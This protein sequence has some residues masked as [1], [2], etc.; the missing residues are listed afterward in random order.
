MTEKNGGKPP[1]SNTMQLWLLCHAGFQNSNEEETIGSSLG[2]MGKEDSDNREMQSV[3]RDGAEIVVQ[4]SQIFGIPR[5]M[6]KVNEEGIISHD[7]PSQIIGAIPFSTGSRSKIIEVGLKRTRS[8]EPGEGQSSHLG[9]IANRTRTRNLKY[10]AKLKGK[11]TGETQRGNEEEPID[12][13]WWHDEYKVMRHLNNWQMSKHT[14]Q[15]ALEFA[16]QRN[17]GSFCT[18]SIDKPENPTCFGLLLSSS[19]H[20]IHSKSIVLFTDGDAR[21]STTSGTMMLMNEE[22]VVFDHYKDR[23]QKSDITIIDKRIE[24]GTQLKKATTMTLQSLLT[25][26]DE[27]KHG[28]TYVCTADVVAIDDGYPWCYL[29]C[30]FCTRRVEHHETSYWCKKCGVVDGTLSRYRVKLDVADGESSAF[31]L[32]FESAG[33][34]VFGQPGYKMREKYDPASVPQAMKSMI[35]GKT[36]KFY[37]VLNSINL[38]EDKRTFVVSHLEDADAATSSSQGSSM[39]T[40]PTKGVRVYNPSDFVT[41]TN[42]SSTRFPSQTPGIDTPH[43]EHHSTIS[44]TPTSVKESAMSLDDILE[45]G[46]Q[47]PQ[48]KVRRPLV[49]ESD[50]DN[51]DQPTK[52]LTRPASNRSSDI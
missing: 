33:R 28:Q 5:D 18:S 13:I 50:D 44:E 25:Q 37:V 52:K 7:G 15:T 9:F 36:K 2:E 16:L 1:N 8:P 22:I 40:T 19:S 26:Y 23:F 27:L 51:D 42:T 14:A 17:P 49:F 11:E 34:S 31:F 12:S 20:F 43:Q 6:V 4:K 32:L 38:Q 24:L 48:R 46:L 41:P 35:V 30:K 47:V 29:G 45:D 39:M 10:A 3:V 21:L